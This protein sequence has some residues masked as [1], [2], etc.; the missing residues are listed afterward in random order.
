MTPSRIGKWCDLSQFSRKRSEADLPV[1]AGRGDILVARVGRNLEQKVIGV[2][3]G[4]PLLT[5]CVYRIKVPKSYRRRVLDQLSSS[6]GKAWLDSRAYGV[7][8]KQLT[9]TD[10]LEFP[11]FL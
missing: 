8:A 5:D 9:K 3:G 6:S 11:L 2:Y 7:G 10:L 1:R 4:F